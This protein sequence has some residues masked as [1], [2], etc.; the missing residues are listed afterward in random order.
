VELAP[1]PLEREEREAVLGDLVESRKSAWQG[2]LGVLGECG[3]RSD[4]GDGSGESY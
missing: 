3:I 2:L 1:R 4:A